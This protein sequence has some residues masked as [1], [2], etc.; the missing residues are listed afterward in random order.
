MARGSTY[1]VEP[2]VSKVMR[3]DVTVLGN[4]VFEVMILILPEKNIFLS[5]SVARSRV[6][7]FT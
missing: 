4:S 1:Q 2:M 3:L 5:T 6:L 7:Q